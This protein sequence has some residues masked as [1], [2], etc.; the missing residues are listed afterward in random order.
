MIEQKVKGD[1]PKPEVKTV[2][3]GNQDIQVEP[4][5]TDNDQQ[6]IIQ[7]YLKE[8]FAEENGTHSLSVSNAENALVLSIL[9]TSTDLMI[10]EE[11]DG[12]EIPVFDLNNLYSNWDFIKNVFSKIGNYKE[13][14]DRLNATVEF[15]NE[16]RRLESSIG[17]KVEVIVAKV[18]NFIEDL[19]NTS[20]EKLEEM[21]KTLESS[22]FLK[23]AISLFNKSGE[24]K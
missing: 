13:F 22:Q 4:F 1:F 10:T 11:K 5:L 20:P 21:K 23:D 2:K 8:L 18:T 14:R 6:A 3:L 12:K 16:Q 24:S 7:V 9:N 19:S 17:S 15:V